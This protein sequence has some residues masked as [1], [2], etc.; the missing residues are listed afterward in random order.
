MDP[1][2]FARL[3]SRYYRGLIKSVKC[4]DGRLFVNDVEV[5][6]ISDVI[7]DFET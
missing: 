6:S 3:V 7:Y 2:V 5:N 1:D 4:I